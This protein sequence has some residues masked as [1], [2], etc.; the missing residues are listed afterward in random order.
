MVV[1]H[2]KMAIHYSTRCLKQIIST[3]PKRPA[4]PSDAFKIIKELA[5]FRQYRGA[6]KQY[7]GEQK[8]STRATNRC[9]EHN[10]HRQASSNKHCRPLTNLITVPIIKDKCFYS[11]SMD[12][13]YINARSVGVAMLILSRSNY[14]W[15]P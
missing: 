5:I 7:F 12:F 9:L 1:L 14:L 6:G 15:M 13:G 8:I 11:K 3:L 2:L 4:I 10:K